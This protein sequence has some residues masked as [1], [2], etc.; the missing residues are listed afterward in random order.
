MAGR[1]QAVPAALLNLLG[2]KTTGLNPSVFPDHVQGVVALEERYELQ[3]LQVFDQTRTVEEG[4]VAG[5]H[6]SIT[7]PPGEVW[8]VYWA[9]AFFTVPAAEAATFRPFLLDSA[10]SI[11]ATIRAAAVFLGADEAFSPGTRVMRLDL[12]G[13]MLAPGF[14]FGWDLATSTLTNPMTVTI[15]ALVSRTPV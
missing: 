7:V 9:S 15:R 8:R 12:R 10:S 3:S 4:T 2:L 14:Q 5:E 6:A 11:S 1:I 13:K